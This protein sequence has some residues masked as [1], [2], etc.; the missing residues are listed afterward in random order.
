MAAGDANIL[1]GGA[2]YW[3]APYATVGG[4]NYSS[5]EYSVHV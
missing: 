5:E 1:A 4:T 2:N 3:D